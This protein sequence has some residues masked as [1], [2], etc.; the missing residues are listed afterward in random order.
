M[1]EYSPGSPFASR[2]FRRLGESCSRRPGRWRLSVSRNKQIC[3]TC[4]PV[5]LPNIAY[6]VPTYYVVSSAE[7]SSNL[8]RFDGVRF[9]HRCSDPRDLD[10]LYRRSRAEGFGSEVKRRILTGT[11]VLSAGYF[12][13]YY[14]KAQRVRRLISQDFDAAFKHVDV[15][16]GPTTP[17][18]AFALGEKNE[19]PVTMYLSDI[20]TVGASLAG[21]PAI[22]VP[23]AP[24]DGL[25]VGLQLM[26]P[27]FQEQS[28][29]N[30]GHAFQTATS[31]HKTRAPGA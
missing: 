8:S 27:H 10:D 20:Y 13:A 9:G 14:L 2:D 26:A 12:D 31:W 30:A 16:L 4:V 21:L 19:D 24:V 15:L 5:S 23:C 29:L 3:A 18:T 28:L 6:A 17:T 25:P 22:S 11:Y 7:C 1:I